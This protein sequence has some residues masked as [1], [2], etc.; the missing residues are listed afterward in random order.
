MFTQLGYH[1]SSLLKSVRGLTIQNTY[2]KANLSA[3]HSGR[4]S[5]CADQHGPLRLCFVLRPP[6]G[7][8]LVSDSQG[9][10]RPFPGCC[11]NSF[12]WKIHPA[13]PHVL[14]HRLILCWESLLGFLL[15]HPVSDTFRQRLSFK[16]CSKYPE[17]SGSFYQSPASIFHAPCASEIS[18]SS[19][20]CSLITFCSITYSSLHPYDTVL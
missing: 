12:S 6:Q 4:I 3:Q 16:F 14:L 8:P 2:P 9:K 17:S 5:V 7:V 1:S 19:C 15:W 11:R 13:Y 18:V 20:C 10:A